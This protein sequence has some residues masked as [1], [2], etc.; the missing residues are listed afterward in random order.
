MSTLSVIIPSYD[1]HEVTALH[2]KAIMNSTRLPDEVIVVNDGGA[3]NLKDLLLKIDRKCPVIYAK[4][5]EDIP[6]NYTGARNLGFFLSRGDYVAIEDTDHIPYPD[7]YEKTMKY[8]EEHKFNGRILFDKRRKV[9]KQDAL[10][11]PVDK[12]TLI[13]KDRVPHDDLHILH[14]DVYLKVK[15]CDERFAGKYAWACTDWR[16]RL[17][18]AKIKTERLLGVYY[19][20]I[21]EA[22]TNTLERRKHPDNYWLARQRKGEERTQSPEGILRFTYTYETL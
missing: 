16:R 19:Y 1:Q 4:I 14:R 20:V 15:G 21:L 3:D 22:E 8:V 10:N 11:N 17:D 12:W 13:P 2:V 7:V 18:R 6:W 5:N 9:Y